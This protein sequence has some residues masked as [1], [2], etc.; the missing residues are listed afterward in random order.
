MP[1]V[2]CGR[3]AE[4]LYC[5]AS[6]RCSSGTLPRR[7][8][9]QR[10]RHV[11]CNALQRLQRL[12]RPLAGCL[13][14]A[15]AATMRAAA[16]KRGV[17]CGPGPGSRPRL[18]ATASP[19]A[20]FESRSNPPDPWHAR[21]GVFLQAQSWCCKPPSSCRRSE[22]CMHSAARFYSHAVK[23]LSMIRAFA[24]TARVPRLVLPEPRNDVSHRSVT[25][26]PNRHH[27][28]CRYDLRSKVHGTAHHSMPLWQ[29]APVLLLTQTC[30]VA[31]SVDRAEIPLAR[32][33]SGHLV[34]SADLKLGATCIA[35]CMHQH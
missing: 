21:P 17:N 32:L 18:H 22:T 19:S 10:P 2:R 24:R 12:P 20:P 29:R 6:V 15:R 26:N 33:K 28:V 5:I 11:R 3:A 27:P 25:T 1:V 14:R 35:S 13:R 23:E 31:D 4:T 7:P 30:V 8:L 9:A 16:V 34:A